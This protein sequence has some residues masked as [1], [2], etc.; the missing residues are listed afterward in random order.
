[1]RIIE[2]KIGKNGYFYLQHSFRVEGEITTKERYLGKKVPRD[3][4]RIKESF[5]EQCYKSHF[6]SSLEKIKKNFQKEWKKYPSPIKE[7][8]KE[9]IAITFTYNTNA[10]EGSTITL[11][12]T[13]ELIEHGIAPPKP[14]KEIKE[15]EAH[16][17]IFLEMLEKKE[18]L[19]AKL[20]LKWHKGLFKETKPDIAG[21]FR[22]YPVRVGNYLAPEWWKVESL[23][24]DLISF[25]NKN[26]KGNAVELAARTHYKFESIH[27][28]GDGNGRIGRLIMN[29]ILWHSDYPML[30]IEYNR[31]GEYYKALAKDE[32]G[33]LNYF[34]KRYLKAHNR[35]LK[36]GSI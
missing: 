15:T 33:F 30:V 26:K 17:K 5:L 11:D 34:I 10:V 22:N 7:K 16:A 32:N 9:Q 13:R 18:K 4:K 35:Y 19:D 6:F 21:E 14:L 27:P 29:Y 36:A 25:Y 8:I 3:I 12:E 31:R 2:R 24:R 1:M 23:I 28:F 20:I